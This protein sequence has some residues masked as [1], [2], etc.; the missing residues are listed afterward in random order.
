MEDKF[1]TDTEVITKNINTFFTE[2]EPSLTKKIEILQKCLTLT[3]K[4]VKPYNQKTS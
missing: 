3:C 1:A 2:I 4:N